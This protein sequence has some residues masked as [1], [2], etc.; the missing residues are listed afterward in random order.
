MPLPATAWPAAASTRSAAL[1]DG[2][3][4]PATV[5]AAFPA[6]LYLDVDG[7]LL[8]V[9]ARGGL[10]LPT[11]LVLARSL[12]PSG[13]GARPGAVVEVGAGRVRLPRA[14]LVAVRTWVPR[15][16]HPGRGA[17]ILPPAP[18]PAPA[19]TP[20]GRWRSEATALAARAVDGDDLGAL[21]D[22]LV[23][24]GPGLT[25]SGDDVLC[26]VLLGLRLGGR[27][28]AVAGLWDAVRPRLGATTTL[29]AALLA[30]AADG[31]AVPDLERLA[32]ALAV[33]DSAAADRAVAAVAAVGHTSGRD[34]LAGFVGALE[35]LVPAL[36]VAS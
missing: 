21:V 28:D 23:G 3:S 9:V 1:V 17:V 29:S 4:R 12:P 25:P 16:V 24:A 30:E 13:W 35:A 19:P 36:E 11:A 32:A 31:Y 7:A 18:A 6:A 5:L 22:A 33:G 15:R 10:R 14:D 34:L 20:A 8:P 26:G 2:P 27:L